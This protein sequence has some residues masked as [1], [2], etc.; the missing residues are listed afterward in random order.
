MTQEKTF[1]AQEVG[2]QFVQEYYTFLNKDSGKLHC[3]YKDE[4]RMTH[5][6]TASAESSCLGQQQ[7]FNK[8]KELDLQGSKVIISSIDTQQSIAGGILGKL[9]DLLRCLPLYFSQ[10]IF[11]V[12]V[13]GQLHSRKENT[14]KPFSQTF[15]LA[16]QPNGYFVLNDIFRFIS[17]GGRSLIYNFLIHL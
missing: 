16:E 13:L 4:S 1:D 17:I 8:F 10:L 11:L 12:T 6:M 14:L 9:T 5:A 3:F 15:F 2:W 7:I